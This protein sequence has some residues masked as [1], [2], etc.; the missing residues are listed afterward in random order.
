MTRKNGYDQIFKHS[1]K[2]AQ[3]KMGVTYFYAE[4]KMLVSVYKGLVDIE[5]VIEHLKKLILFY[6]E[7]DVVCS[8]VDISGVLGSFAK[9]MAF[10]ESD[11]YPVAI[12]NG[13]KVQA[14]VASDDLIIKNLTIRLEMMA[15]MFSIE[16][17]VFKT[18][19]EAEEWVKS[20]F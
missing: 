1:M 5:L 14:Y 4:H 20:N 18:R 9:I 10:L 17:G 11:Y 13:L 8:V 6:K 3:N 19:V 7:N 12:K 2:I 16:S 15:S